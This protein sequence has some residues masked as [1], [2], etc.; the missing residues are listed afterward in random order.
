MTGEVDISRERLAKVEFL[1]RKTAS[2][3]HDHERQLTAMD[4]RITGLAHA[5][6]ATLIAVRASSDATSSLVTTLNKLDS[7]VDEWTA[8]FSGHL[9]SDERARRS[10]PRIATALWMSTI[11]MIAWVG[12]FYVAGIEALVRRVLAIVFGTA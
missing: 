6:E 1:A 4:D 5:H 9:L 10:L 2:T 12:S 3:V 11:A 8:T 7:R